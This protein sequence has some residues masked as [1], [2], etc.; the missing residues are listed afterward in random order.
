MKTWSWEDVFPYEFIDSVEK[1]KYN[2]ELRKQDFYSSL[3]YEDFD[4]YL[5]VSNLLKEK[6]VGNCSELCYQNIQT[7]AFLAYIQYLRTSEMS[8]WKL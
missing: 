3:N 6:T 2:K 1:L 5:K 8:V 7:V 4:H